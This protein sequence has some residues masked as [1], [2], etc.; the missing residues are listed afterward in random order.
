MKTTFS[1]WLVPL[2]LTIFLSACA[3]K[4][5]KSVAERYLTAIQVGDY[6]GA[7]QF[8]SAESQAPLAELA[9]KNQAIG[10]HIIQFEVGEEK[11]SG[12][13]AVVEFKQDGN[14]HIL[15]LIQENGEWKVI[16]A[17]VDPNSSSPGI[18]NPQDAGY[19]AKLFLEALHSGEVREAMKYATEDAQRSLD[20]LNYN[21]KRS[22]PDHIKILDVKQNDQYA[23]V[24][25]T[26]NDKERWLELVKENDEWKAEWKHLNDDTFDDIFEQL[27][28]V[29]GN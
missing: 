19:I 15:S 11:I 21:S 1:R 5:P 14:P 13:R 17:A 12:E 22:Q 3:G 4:S 20:M 18:A 29:T 2:V 7:Q 8:A 27:E 25:Y 10:D 23:T 26:K 16:Y 6:K 24:H 9:A 28:N